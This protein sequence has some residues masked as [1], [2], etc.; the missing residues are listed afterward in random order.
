MNEI[1]L[2]LPGVLLSLSAVMLA[3]MSPGPNILAVIGTSMGVGRQEGIALALGVGCG[4]FLWVL[5]AVLGFTAI[6]SKYAVVMLALK[7]LGGIYLLWLGYKALRSAASAKAVN[8]TTLELDDKVAY[9]KRG[10]AVQ[11]TNP[12]AAVAILAIV[13]IG[14]HAD[15]PMWVGS[16]IV[17]GATLLS[18]GG[19]VIY[20]LAFSTQPMVRIYTRARR[21]IE[22]ALGAFFCV[23]GVKLLTER[24]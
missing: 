3:L 13:S 16:S 1:Q 23:M 7:I 12:K 8:L 5:M 14:V 17:I 2:F 20:A 24:T 19:H 10:V 22:A 9:F 6:I 21:Y 11:M 4:T 18:V 15:A